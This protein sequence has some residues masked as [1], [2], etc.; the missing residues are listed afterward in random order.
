MVRRIGLVFVLLAL[1][2]GAQ[3]ACSIPS[4]PPE[5]SEPTPEHSPTAAQPAIATPAALP[6]PPASPPTPLLPSTEHQGLTWVAS[7]FYVLGQPEGGWQEY[8]VTVAYENT[9]DR[10]IN[11][12]ITSESWNP[13]IT[14]Q[15]GYAYEPELGGW[16]VSCVEHWAGWGIA[17]PGYFQYPEYFLG[18]NTGII[19]PGFRIRG[20]V[21]YNWPD[22]RPCV[23]QITL[24]F[25]VGEVLHPDGLALGPSTVVPLS[26]MQ[27]SYGPMDP[28]VAFGSLPATIDMGKAQVT[29]GRVA[30]RTGGLV[31]IVLD[32]QNPDPGRE[33]D[34][35]DP[36]VGLIDSQGYLSA[37]RSA[38]GQDF[39]YRWFA[40]QCG[41]PVP[42]EFG[43][44]PM[45]Q[46]QYR[47]CLPLRPG[48]TPEER[49]FLVACGWTEQA[50]EA[51]S[52]I[53]QHQKGV[54]HGLSIDP[55]H[56]D[57]HVYEVRISQ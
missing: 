47:T 46:A 43:L 5:S 36:I 18:V 56:K 30:L 54:S 35:Y 29:I 22:R 42:V 25:K 40:D 13:Q 55:E 31:E 32:Y 2:A 21:T 53:G 20:A 48:A 12:H 9:S 39:A 28:S 37:P 26:Q 50:E 49:F 51:D 38:W 16:F 11:E 17:S 7:G 15:E 57:C 52:T 1:T 8:Q 44:G 14:T 3:L 19:P 10:F 6:T 4:V 41:D 34:I 27:E 33:V 45:Q 23:G 24:E